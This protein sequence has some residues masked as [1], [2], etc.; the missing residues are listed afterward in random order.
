M[1]TVDETLKARQNVHGNFS[2]NSSYS[3]QFKNIIEESQTG[4]V[5][6]SDVQRESLDMIVHKIARILA[7]DPNHADHWHDIAGYATL[8]EQ[9]I[10]K[11]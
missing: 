8:A 7:G 9:R 10:N 2:D 6:M 4:K 3:Q 5:R 1:E 11:K